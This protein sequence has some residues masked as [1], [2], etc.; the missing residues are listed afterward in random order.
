MTEADWLA[1]TDPRPMLA[2]LS[3]RA[4]ASDRKLRLFGVAC[5][6]SIWHGLR[7]ERSR[8]AVEVAERFA[9]G[10]TTTEELAA[11][12]DAA[13]TAVD[14]CMGDSLVSEDQALA[15]CGAASEDAAQVAHDALSYGWDGDMEASKRRQAALLRD[16]LGNPF[17]PPPALAPSVLAFNGGTVPKLAAAIYE[18]R[19]FG[20]LP[21]LADALEDAGCTDPAILNHCRSGG[22][23]ARGCWV[24]DLVL[25]RA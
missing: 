1:A 15:A 2:Y 13:Y 18:E 16:L 12:Y 20:R 4:G 3:E 24:V 11:A 22:E 14:D 10:R 9:D 23:H 8:S 19:A 6:R 21:V 17:R 25:G 7:D 5:C